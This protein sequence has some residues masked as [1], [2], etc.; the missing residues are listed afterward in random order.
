MKM[1]SQKDKQERG[2]KGEAVITASL[3]KAALWNY[4]FVNAG[5]GTVFDK[6]V[7]LPGG[8]YGLEIKVR[9]E[10]RIGYNEKSI[11]PNERKGLNKFVDLVG[12]DYAFIV[13]IWKTES[14]ERVFLI[15]WVDVREEVLSGIRGSIKMLDFPELQKVTGGWDMS[16][17]K[18]RC[19]N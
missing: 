9:Q 11:T 10:P 15:K 14:F 19:Q 2:V 16:W 17:V 18:G 4:K 3:K 8:G 7:V 13:G 5:F 1:K 12:R 6:L